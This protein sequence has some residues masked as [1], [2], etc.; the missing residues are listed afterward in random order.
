M[1][2]RT[3]RCANLE[4]QERRPTLLFLVRTDERQTFIARTVHP[5]SVER[6]AGELLGPLL[7][8]VICEPR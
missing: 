1:I 5:R 3:Q 6:M 7:I 8:Y 4:A 2:G